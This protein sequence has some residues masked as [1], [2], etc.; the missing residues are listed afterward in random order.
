MLMNAS[1]RACITHH[2][3][4]DTSLTVPDALYE[5][6]DFIEFI[7]GTRSGTPPRQQK[8]PQVIPVELSKQIPYSKSGGGEAAAKSSDPRYFL[9]IDKQKL[10]NAKDFGKVCEAYLQL[11]CLFT[12]TPSS[13]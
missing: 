4:I 11:G 3:K 8:P 9:R 10:S 5:L 13:G 7:I 12:H 6:K 1:L 2:V